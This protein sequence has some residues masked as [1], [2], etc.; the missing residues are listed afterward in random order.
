M[1]LSLLL[2]EKAVSA[3]LEG[4]WPEAPSVHQRGNAGLDRIC[5]ADFFDDWVF[6]GCVPVEEIAVVKAPSP[7]LNPAAIKTNGRT[8]GAKLRHLYEQG[9]TV[10]LGNLQRVIPELHT[11]SREIQVETGFSNYVHAFMTP[12]G[13]Q[14]LR[15]HWDQQF[16]I[17][18]QMSGVKR[19]QLWKPVIESPMRHFGESTRVWDERWRE[20]WIEMGPDLEVDLKPGQSLIVPRGW[21]HNPFTP[22][23]EG[24]STHLTFAIR[25]RTPYW[26]A[27]KLLERLLERPDFRRV[28]LPEEVIGGG[29]AGKLHQ[30]R[31][32]LVEALSQASDL[33]GFAHDVRDAALSELEYTT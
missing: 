1:S 29:L 28:L 26:L 24:G 9:Y 18:A 2:P 5:T 10:R 14:G 4:P 6:T 16:A 13:E 17:I 30:V 32:M 27:E 22:E 11:I 3:L 8:D 23:G 33:Q 20:R 15:H 19:W 7:S 25:E 12:A 31:H 21:V